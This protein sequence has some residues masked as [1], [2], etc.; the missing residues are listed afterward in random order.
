LEKQILFLFVSIAY[1]DTDYAEDKIECKSTK[2]CIPISWLSTHKTGHA[3]NDTIALFT[4][5]AKYMSVT[6]C[7]SQISLL[8]NQH[9]EFSKRY[10]NVL[11]FVII[12]MQ[13]YLL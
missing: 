11:I 10:E 13:F 2:W 4:I 8:K 1:R 9:E 12:L 5:E 7:Y 6:R 3:K